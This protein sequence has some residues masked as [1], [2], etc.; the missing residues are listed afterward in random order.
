MAFVKMRDEF[1][2]KKVCTPVR[3]HK[4]QVVDFEWPGIA[5]LASKLVGIISAPSGVKRTAMMGEI[6]WKE[7]MLKKLAPY[8]LL[9][10]LSS[11][12]GGGL[13]LNGLSLFDS[14]SLVLVCGS[15]VARLPVLTSLVAVCVRIAAGRI[16]VGCF[17][18]SCLF[19]RPSSSLGEL[20]SVSDS[21]ALSGPL[22]SAFLGATSIGLFC[23]PSFSLLLSAISEAAKSQRIS[24]HGLS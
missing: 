1:L 20:L 5:D 3:V 19:S 2:G 14:D 8:S 16:F 6:Q 24:K 4:V 18:G 15:F 7:S 9:I 23:S 22:Y 21:S 11:G 13:R 12:I 10:I 17:F